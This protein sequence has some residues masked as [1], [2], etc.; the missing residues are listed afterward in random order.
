MSCSLPACRSWF[1]LVFPDPSLGQMEEYAFVPAGLPTD[2]TFHFAT[3]EL[4][5]LP[6]MPRE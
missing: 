2:G 4:N 3:I 1:E 6:D 5:W